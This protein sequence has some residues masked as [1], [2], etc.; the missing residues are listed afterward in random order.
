MRACRDFFNQALLDQR[1]SLYRGKIQPGCYQKWWIFAVA[2]IGRRLRQQKAVIQTAI[3]IICTNLCR[4]EYTYPRAMQ[5]V[6]DKIPAKINM[7]LGVTLATC[8]QY[9]SK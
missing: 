6:L 8:K 9:I 1:R 4:T 7:A 2:V 3:T 5:A